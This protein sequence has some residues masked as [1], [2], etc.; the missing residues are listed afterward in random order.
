M[1]VPSE[2]EALPAIEAEWQRKTEELNAREVQFAEREERLR[3]AEA[4]IKRQQTMTTTL[5]FVEEL[6]QQGRILPRQREGLVAFIAALD[7]TEEVAFAEPGEDEKAQ[8]VQVKTSTAAYIQR[9]LK[10]LPVQ[11]DFLERSTDGGGAEPTLS[12]AAPDGYSVDAAGLEMHR[13]ILAYAKK[14]NLDFASALMAT[15][16]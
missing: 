2:T 7:E 11:V 14:H 9:F 5:H 16:K 15:N 12:F 3:L 8:P 10:E 6:I 4:A 13:N 1:P